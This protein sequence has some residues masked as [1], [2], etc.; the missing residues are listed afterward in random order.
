MSLGLGR[1]GGRVTPPSLLSQ[2]PLSL[3]KKKEK[4]RKKKKREKKQGPP[5]GRA[6]PESQT[7]YWEEGLQ[8]PSPPLPFPN[9]E[10]VWGLG[11]EVTTSSPKLG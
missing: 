5:E 11:E 1:E 8:P 3:L 2:T 10:Q 9:P 7:C 6:K 4:K